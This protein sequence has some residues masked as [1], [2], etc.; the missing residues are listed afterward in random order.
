[1]EVG[2]HTENEEASELYR[3]A[4]AIVDPKRK[5]V[6]I[7]DHVINDT[8]SMCSSCV[9]LYDRKGRFAITDRRGSSLFWNSRFH[10]CA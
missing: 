5:V 6:K 8:L 1:M 9:R 4:G 7:P 2:I 3:K 10:Q